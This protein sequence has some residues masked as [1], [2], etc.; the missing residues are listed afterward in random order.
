[1]FCPLAPN[2]LPTW[3]QRRAHSPGHAMPQPCGGSDG[4]LTPGAGLAPTLS[5]PRA[6]CYWGP[7]LPTLSIP[8]VRCYWGPTRP[9][10]SMPATGGLPLAPWLLQKRPSG[11][12]GPPLA[13]AAC[14]MAQAHPRAHAVAAKRKAKQCGTRGSQE[15]P[16]PSTNRAQ[17]R[18]TSEF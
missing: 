2:L 8:S 4:G 12:A 13:L 7:T 10:L 5:I 16:Q 11:Q 18:L 1:M 15:I 9:T 6:Q 14:P 17:P 3:P